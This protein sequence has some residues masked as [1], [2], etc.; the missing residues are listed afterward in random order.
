MIGEGGALI[1]RREGRACIYT[2][3]YIYI[4]IYIYV[5]GMIGE[6][7][8]SV[9]RREGRACAIIKAVKSPLP[10]TQMFTDLYSRYIYIHIYKY[11]NLYVYIHGCM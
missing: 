3:I 2:Y 1:V 7:G 4:Y 8:A 11:V 10:D 9:V 6:G 5:Y